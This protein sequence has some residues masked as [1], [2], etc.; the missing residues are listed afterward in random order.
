MT[1]SDWIGR[2]LGDRY[3]VDDVLGTGGMSSVYKATV[4]NLKRVVAIK[5]IHPHLSAN[6]DFVSR[7]KE[8]ASSVAQ[9]R[10][11]NIVQVFDF[12][13]DGD[14][15]YMVMEFVP[16]ET[17]TIGVTWSPRQSRMSA[18]VIAFSRRPMSR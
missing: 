9:L 16:G 12:D 6:P 18:I 3:V 17:G 2:T 15:Y 8:E 11:P 4:P 5:L 7:F 13:N 10:H 1:Q 14:T